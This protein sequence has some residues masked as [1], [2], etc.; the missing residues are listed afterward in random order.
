MTTK[1]MKRLAARLMK[2]DDIIEMIQSKSIPDD[3]ELLPY[4]ERDVGDKCRA[5][6]VSL[7]D[8]TSPA[9]INSILD[10]CTGWIMSFLTKM[11]KTLPFDQMILYS[12]MYP[13]QLNEVSASDCKLP[14][15]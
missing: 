2:N 8:D 4:N 10:Y 12:Y 9:S 1:L 11:L 15:K 7:G 14:I 3:L 6:V 5:H 13:A